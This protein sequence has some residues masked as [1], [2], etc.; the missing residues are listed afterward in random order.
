MRSSTRIAPRLGY[1]ESSLG[2][3]HVLDLDLSSDLFG[4]TIVYIMALM[5]MF[6]WVVRQ[7]TEIESM[8]TS[9][10]RIAECMRLEPEAPLVEEMRPPDGWPQSGR[11][12]ADG[13]SLR[14]APDEPLVL[15]DLRFYINAAEKVE[16]PVSEFSTVLII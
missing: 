16:L 13:V 12:D 8:M 9:V 14:Y 10:E 1:D 7:S 11:I 15:K 6:Q 5:G 2:L 3:S 4:L